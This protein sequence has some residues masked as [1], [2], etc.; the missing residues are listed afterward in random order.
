MFVVS[1]GPYAQK[2]YFERNATAA[3]ALDSIRNIE[4]ATV[5]W[6]HFAFRTFDSDGCGI[7]AMSRVFTDLGYVR[8]DE[9]RF[10]KKKLQAY[11]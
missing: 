7:E 4:G 6:D 8:R 5:H 10:E 3:R 11:W 9:L 2:P 1:W